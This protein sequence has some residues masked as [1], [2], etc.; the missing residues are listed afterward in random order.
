MAK[1][2]ASNLPATAGSAASAAPG[3]NLPALYDAKDYAL[4]GIGSPSELVS[5]VRA[6]LG[7]GSIKRHELPRI[8]WPSGG[9][10][11][12]NLPN[13][14][15]IQLVQEITGVIVAFMDTRVYWKESLNDGAAGKPPDCYSDDTVTGKGKPGGACD[16]C[17][18]AEFGSKPSSSG[19]GFDAG[20]ACALRRVLFIMMPD[21]I[22]P[23][24]VSLPPTG[25][26]PSRQYFIGLTGKM[27]YVNGVVTSIGGVSKKSS[28]GKPY[29]EATFRRVNTLSKDAAARFA[30]LAQI[31]APHMAEAARA[32]NEAATTEEAKS[33][34]VEP[35]V[36]GQPVGGGGSD[37]ASAP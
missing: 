34:T 22:M 9:N 32:A 11:A 1:Q 31:F 12:F 13:A 2:A 36:E 6:N 16:K 29:V 33:E 14:D 3:N 26:K 18:F 25:L 15:G 4:M 30:A 7:P 37:D 19:Q 23:Y 10:V 17:K 8:V 20:Q 35:T 21:S 27:Q 24:T 5:I 28:G